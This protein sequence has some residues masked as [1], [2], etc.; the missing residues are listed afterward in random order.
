ML[1]AVQSVGK[2]TKASTIKLLSVLQK[3]GALQSDTCER[4]LRLDI[5]SAVESTG[6][7]MTPYGPIIQQVK[8]DAPRLQYWDICHP[9]ACLW[10]MTQHSAAFRGVMR[11]STADSRKLPAILLGQIRADRSCASTG[12]LLIGHIT[13]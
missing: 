10:Y 8:L 1:Q 3:R 7:T 12:V 4:Q 13:C 2:Q 6:N 9:F 11:H 5:Q